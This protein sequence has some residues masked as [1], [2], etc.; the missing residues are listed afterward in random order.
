[1][2]GN[3]AAIICSVVCLCSYFLEHN[4]HNPVFIMSGLW[5]I[6]LYFAN[7]RLYSMYGAS[8]LTYTLIALGIIFFGIGGLINKGKYY[9]LGEAG[10]K[11]LSGYAKQRGSNEINYTLLRVL[12]IVSAVVMIEP[13]MR[14]MRQMVAGLA[15]MNTIRMDNEIVYRN[16]LVKMLSNYVARP[17]AFA[18]IPV[19]ASEIVASQKRDWTVIL[20]TVV[21]V[22]ER[23]LLEGGRMIIL[24][25]VVNLF[26]AFSLNK[27]HKVQK[28]ALQERKQKTCT[29][30]LIGI[31]S[32]V[33]LVGIYFVSLSRGVDVDEFLFS[34]YAYL[35]GCVPNLSIRLDQVIAHG[36]HTYGVAS[37]NGYFAFLFA[38]LG[39][40]GFDTPE[41]Y[42]HAQALMNVESGVRIR[43]YGS[44]HFNA[45]VG[46]YFYMYLDGGIWGVI[47]GMTIFGA[48]S[49]HFY[50]MYRT[51]HRK[52]DQLMY[53]LMAQ[54]LINSMVRIQFVNTYYAI[55]FVYLFLL[56][57]DWRRVR[58]II[59]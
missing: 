11:R 7:M 56:T 43:E 50:K 6:I 10:R 39:N 51:F 14:S 58:G 55:A 24:T 25:I 20:S 23:V 13:A 34:T 42:T 31:V 3:E 53:L 8:S 47:I 52:R 54:G 40:L 16:A 49:Y 1:M 36:E 22:I 28:R 15:T 26:V 2:S 57:I 27:D 18:V 30:L 17:F 46:P 59:R 29:M 9:V 48:A 32:I 38:V 5:S 21:I 19:F 4:M 37:L 45:F 35:C 41:F 12:C 44:A 33:A